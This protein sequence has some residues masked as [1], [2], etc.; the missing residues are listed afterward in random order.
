MKP[1][2]P[3]QLP[4]K[5]IDLLALMPLIGK[6]NR[7]IATLEGLFL[8]R[9]CFLK[10]GAVTILGALVCGNHPGDRLG[11]RSHV[12]GYVDVPQQIAQDKQDFVD[13]V[14]QLMESSLGYL[15][16]TF[17]WASRRKGEAR[18]CRNTRSRCCVRP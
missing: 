8:E 2:E 1:F 17:R 9:R 6:T 14:L 7:A 5:D 12:H 10:D 15:C 13:N 3:E 4:P 16:A 18:P 11:F